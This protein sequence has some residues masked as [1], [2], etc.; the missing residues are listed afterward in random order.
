MTIVVEGDEIVGVVD[1]ED[2]ACADDQEPNP[3]G[4]G[5]HRNEEPIAHVGD[6][7][8]LSPPRRAGIAGP[9]MLEHREDH[10]Q[11]EGNGDHLLDGLAEHQGNLHG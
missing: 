2:D 11:P 8:P 3:H 7:F 1:I 10:R 6:D 4:A 9:E 5:E